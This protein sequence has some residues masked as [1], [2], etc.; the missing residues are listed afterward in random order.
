LA[1]KVGIGVGVAVAI[2]AALL[3]LAFFFYR[4]RKNSR[5]N[6]VRAASQTRSPESSNYGT[7]RWL[8]RSELETLDKPVEMN[9][10][11]EVSELEGNS[12]GMS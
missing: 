8:S 7:Q 10:Q 9:G 1:A 3:G 11:K 12:R 4:R 6:E 2:I 5:I